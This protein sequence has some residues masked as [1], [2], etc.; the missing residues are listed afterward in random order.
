GRTKNLI[1]SSRFNAEA[2]AQ[3]YQA[4]QYDVLLEV[5]RAY[6]STL[7]AQ[8]VVRVA[9]ETVA[10]RQL[11]LDQVT[12]LAYNNL[13]SQLDVSFADV[14]VSEARL[15]LLRAQNDV[16]SSFADL[17][18]ALG[19][20]QV[21]NY[22]LAD[23]LLPQSPPPTPD[24]LVAD[25]LNTRP[26]IVSFRAARDAAARFAEAENDLVRP[27]VNVVGAVGYLPLI[28]EGG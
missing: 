28:N 21:T 9:N 2:S 23:E 27:T 3:N 16:E 20:S 11:L 18:R 10:A 12:T 5:D 7:H 4:T 13:R 26:E 14:N 19:T 1:A 24:Q 22:Q 17:T 15:L 8:A 25:A 6:F